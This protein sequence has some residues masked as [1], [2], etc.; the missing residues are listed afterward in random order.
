M[1]NSWKTL[2][3]M[4]P[5]ALV[6]ACTDGARAPAEAAMAAAGA[7][8]DSLK[9]D[10][11]K[12]APEEVKKLESVYGVAKDSMANKDYQGALTF[13][14]D[15]PAKA[16]EVLAKA[17]TAK[18]ELARAWKD[19]GDAITRTMDEAKHRLS[20]SRKPPPGMDKAALAKAH[21][22]LAS[23]EAG[24]TAAIEQHKSGDWTGAVAK[25]KDLNAKGQELLQALGAR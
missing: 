6:A 13:T 1:T 23:L 15:I 4:V 17:E 3:L 21:D 25:A 24:W 20:E 18:I 8:M 22:D 16:R 7:A 10:A 12:Y 2:A 19:A 9:G 5:L 14:K 11:A